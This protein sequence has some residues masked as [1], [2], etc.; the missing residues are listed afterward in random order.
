MAYKMKGSRGK[1]AMTKKPGGTRKKGG[2]ASMMSSHKGKK[3]AM[4]SSHN[5]G[6]Y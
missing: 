5:P 2:S 4:K 6:R 3:K 1:P